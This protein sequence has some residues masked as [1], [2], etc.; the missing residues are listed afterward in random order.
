MNEW[1]FPELERM[2]MELE[3]EQ[4]TI[5]FKMSWPTSCSQHIYAIYIHLCHQLHMPI[6][7]DI[8]K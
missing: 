5:D 6:Y 8:P 2:S 7:N 4:L 1:V 3:R